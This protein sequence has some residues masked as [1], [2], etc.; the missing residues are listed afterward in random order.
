MGKNSGIHR[1]LLQYFQKVILEGEDDLIK[2]T[3]K[4][5]VS[6]Y[7]K[8]VWKD[9]K[10]INVI[11][12]ACMGTYDKSVKLA[13]MFFVDTTEKVE[14]ELNSSSEEEDEDDYEK[15]L[16]KVGPSTFSS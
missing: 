9:T 7:T 10:T 1:E 4:I 13:C 14:E 15:N 2:R 3:V 16:Q 12:S 8:N 5:L 6:L 11:S